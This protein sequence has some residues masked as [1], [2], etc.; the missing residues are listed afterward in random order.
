MGLEEQTLGKHRAFSTSTKEMGN[1]GYMDSSYPARPWS[2]G[3][4]F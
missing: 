3:D 4:N 1:V 2:S